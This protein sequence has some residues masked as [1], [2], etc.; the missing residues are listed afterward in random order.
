M[1]IAIAKE[2]AKE[3]DTGTGSNDSVKIKITGISEEDVLLGFKKY[4]LSGYKTANEE[5]TI[6][7]PVPAHGSRAT[8]QAERMSEFFCLCG[9]EASVHYAVN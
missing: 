4:G 9:Y 6:F 8:A 3:T 7:P 1:A 2:A 5:Y